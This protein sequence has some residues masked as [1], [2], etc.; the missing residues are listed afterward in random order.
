[1]IHVE[2]NPGAEVTLDDAK[3]HLEAGWA[4]S[5]GLDHTLLLIDMGQIRS[6]S[7]EARVHY[8]RGDSLRPP[9]SAENRAIAI[10]VG[11]VL[12]K[13]I[14]NFFLGMNRPAVPVRLFVER[15]RALA[16]LRGID[17]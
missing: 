8:A 11:S 5:A 10:V 6:V 12:G 1:V 14:A 9:G 16:W 4:L 17:G 3:E 2:V 15:D 13:A 7:R